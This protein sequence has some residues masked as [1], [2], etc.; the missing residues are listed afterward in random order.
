MFLLLTPLYIVAPLKSIFGTKT[1][2]G[3]PRQLFVLTDGTHFGYFF[4]LG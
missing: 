1:Q 3:I 4:L 2:A